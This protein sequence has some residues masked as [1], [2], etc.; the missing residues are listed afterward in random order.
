MKTGSRGLFIL[1]ITWMVVSFI[2]FFWVKNTAI[3]VIWLC[4]GMVELMIAFI[5]KKK[6]QKK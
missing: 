1:A 6:E 3:G 4:L 2:W 5:S